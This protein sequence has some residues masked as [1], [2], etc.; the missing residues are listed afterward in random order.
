MYQEKLNIMGKA[1]YF[2]RVKK[3]RSRLH[4]TSLSVGKRLKDGDFKEGKAVGAVA[5]L[6]RDVCVCASYTRL[7]MLQHYL[8]L[9]EDGGV[10][11]T[12]E[13]G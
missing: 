13:S 1:K 8:C 4:G 9:W 7:Q 11:M 5:P 10:W 6:K 12:V 2:H 3:I